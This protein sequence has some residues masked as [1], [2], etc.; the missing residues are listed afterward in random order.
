METSRHALS[1]A[2]WL[3]IEAFF[4]K[5]GKAG[6]PWRDHRLVMNGILWILATGAPWRD[7]PAGFGPWKTVY[8]RFRRW[9]RDGF[10]DKLLDQLNARRHGAGKIDWDLFC[11]DGSVVRAHK[12]AAGARKKGGLHPSQNRTLWAV[13]A[14]VSPQNSI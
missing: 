13:A 5:N 4:P 11:I 10:W 9:T 2:Q 7:L 8:D 6:R 12:H 1:D 3:R 14:G